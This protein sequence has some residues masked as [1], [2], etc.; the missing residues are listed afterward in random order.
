MK[1]DIKEQAAKRKEV[2]ATGKVE[3][4]LYKSAKQHGFGGKK[5]PSWRNGLLTPKW[6]ESAPAR[7]QDPKP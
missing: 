2:I 4:S 5:H 3:K 6:L 7:F 1:I